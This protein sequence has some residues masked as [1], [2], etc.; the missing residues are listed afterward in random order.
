MRPIRIAG[1]TAALAFSACQL[2]PP[3]DVTVEAYSGD[4]DR[5]LLRWREVSGADAYDVDVRVESGDWNPLWY[6]IEPTLAS[7]CCT[8]SPSVPELVQLGFR[9]RARDGSRT[10]HWSDSPY[11]MRGVRPPRDLTFRDEADTYCGPARTVL[12]WTNT[13]AVSD[14]V[15]VE[16]RTVPLVGDA[17]G[18]GVVLEASANAGSFVETDYSGLYDAGSYDYRVVAFAGAVASAPREVRLGPEALA[19]VADGRAEA[20]GSTVTLSW[21]NAS[22]YATEVDVFRDFPLYPI[23][24]VDASTGRFEDAGVA[25]GPHAYWLQPRSPERDLNGPWSLVTAF[26]DDGSSPLGVQVSAR[27]FETSELMSRGPD[28]RFWACRSGLLVFDAGGVDAFGLPSYSWPASPGPLIDAA[29]RPHVLLHQEDLASSSYTLHH[30]WVEGCT[31]HD[32]IAAPPAYPHSFGWAALAADGTLRAASQGWDGTIVVTGNSSGSWT[33]DTL[34]AT[35]GTAIHALAVAP[36]GTSELLLVDGAAVTVVRSLPGGGWAEEPV[37]DENFASI[38]T[39][40]FFVG[41]DG[42][43]DWIF[44]SRLSSTAALCVRHRTATGWLASDVL[45]ASG[46]PARAALSSA[47]RLAVLVLDQ[48]ASR[49]FVRDA[50]IWSETRFPAGWTDALVGFDD[51]GRWWLLGGSGPFSA[52]V[53]ALYEER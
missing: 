24:T 37:P 8:V 22:A 38:E 31:L 51:L 40:G 7:A 13:S 23:A 47:G 21:T 9:V 1:A 35:P 29:G 19:P 30:A 32:E 10:S 11:L 44:T 42:A 16:R 6:G 12:Q 34:V 5:V 18:W 41:S 46:S 48:S 36:D 39:A 43:A 49:L 28:G 33:S 15:R 14:F 25:V 53:S 20:S 27:A 45:V 2:S 17:G 52:P 50:G 26:V 4:F 3:R